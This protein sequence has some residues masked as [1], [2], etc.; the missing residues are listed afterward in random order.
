MSQISYNNI[1]LIIKPVLAALIKT[2]P[3]LDVISSSLSIVD[4]TA[5]WIVKQNKDF[6]K[7]INKALIS[8]IKKTKKQYKNIDQNIWDFLFKDHSIEIIKGD[9]LERKSNELIESLK[10]G[11]PIYN[12][13]L[14]SFKN[15]FYKYV[16]KDNL[17]NNY[18]ELLLTS[19]IH[20]DVINIGTDVTEILGQMTEFKTLSDSLIK[21]ETD[22]EDV[23]VD[24]WN[25]KKV[26]KDNNTISSN[27]DSRIINNLS[28]KIEACHYAFLYFAV[29]IPEYRNKM[30]K[31]IGIKTINNIS[32]L[33]DYDLPMI[34]CEIKNNSNQDMRIHTPMISGD[35][36]INKNSI[37]A[38]GFANNDLTGA[39]LP[40]NSKT[41]FEIHGPV[42]IGVVKSFINNQIDEVY[43]EDYN[44]TKYYVPKEQIKK[45]ADY[46]KSYCSDEADL[47]N[48][49]DKYFIG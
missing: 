31:Y 32:E 25:N 22:K 5:E 10:N 36:V 9:E 20:Q 34:K 2:S 33:E 41:E 43:V 1:S 39:L 4:Y 27:H 17:L 49:H 16:S 11:D 23:Y 45:V 15:N 35:I 29:Q 8:A 48:R 46:F 26:L 18:Y 28:I 38:I 13:I 47:K 21:E 30:G 7:S 6:D 44:E 40:K 12:K 37:D 42:I 3:V 19:N 14:H 24:L